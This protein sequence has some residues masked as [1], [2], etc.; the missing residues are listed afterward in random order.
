MRW[1]TISPALPSQ[2]GVFTV[3]SKGVGLAARINVLVGAKPK[4]L[5][6]RQEYKPPFNLD[7]SGDPLEQR[8]EPYVETLLVGTICRILTLFALLPDSANS[9]QWRRDG[10]TWQITQW[11]GNRPS[12]GLLSESMVF[13]RHKS[14]TQNANRGRANKISSVFR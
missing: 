13:Y 3:E 7:R 9:A 5:M 8:R 10:D 1:H 11:N 12:A 14:M 2:D 6:R 4:F